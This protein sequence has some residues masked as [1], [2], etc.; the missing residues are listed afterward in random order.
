MKT[1]TVAKLHEAM[2][3]QGV[4][5]Y[6][7]DIA[8]RCPMC[9]TV[10]SIRSLMN[11]GATKEEAEKR[12]AFSCEGRLRNAPS[13]KNGKPGL[14]NIRGCDWTLGGLLKLHTIEVITEDGVHHP[15]FELAN[16]YEAKEL[17]RE[18]TRF[19]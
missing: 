14:K 1:I 12:I 17:V 2:K 13:A 15:R 16:Q 11:A 8:F 9:N 7:E 5:P 18:M 3:A 6:Q 10:Q 19:P 4:G